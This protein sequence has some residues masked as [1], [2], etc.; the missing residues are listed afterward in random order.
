MDRKTTILIAGIGTI[1]FIALFAG[2]W[3]IGIYNNIITLENT[4][5]EKWA[6]VENQYQR[7][8]DL[9][10]NL[11]STVKGY[12]AHEK[13]IFEEVTR[14]RSQW[15]EAVKSGDREAE[16]QAANELD[17]AISRLLLVV[18][19]YPD[20]KANQ[21]FLELQAQLE[22]T[23]NRIAVER[24]RYNTA[25]KEHNIYI[26]KIPNSFMAG[27]MG[28][29]DKEYFEAEEGAEKVPVVEF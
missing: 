12:A 26:K 17:S 6:Q 29:T 2:L 25:V 14:M 10:P 19:N 24:M 8:A 16:I 15:G 27:M 3:F 23:E 7:R 4:V 20:L 22:G 21:N 13:E 5:E 11:V 28:R 9:I 18:E 1:A